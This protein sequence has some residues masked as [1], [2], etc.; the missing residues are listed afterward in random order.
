VYRYFIR[1]TKHL[2]RDYGGT[3]AI[4]TGSSSG[5]GFEIAKQLASEGVNCVLVGRD[6]S[7]LT[8]AAATLTDLYKVETRVVSIDASSPEPDF[9]GLIDLCRSLPCVSILVNNVGVHNE[10]P[11]NV[12]DMLQGDSKRII[13]VNC[14]F[15]TEIIR[16]MV[17]YLKPKPGREK[18]KSIIV[19]VGSLTSQMH[20]PMLSVYAGT[21]A[22]LEHFSAC[23]AAELEPV[24]IEVV[25]L[26]PGIT[27][28]SM[29]GISTPSLFCPTPAVMADA[30]VRVVGRG[31]LTCVPYWPHAIL[32]AVN[33]WVP[34]S[35]AWSA[36][37]QMHSVKRTEMLFLGQHNKVE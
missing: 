36:V 7:R 6:M 24:G 29:S 37:R 14:L 15:Q 17:P 4:I 28:G 10:V 5:I 27:T 25:C 13:T 16:C 18:I 33:Q 31:M 12:S 20:M 11:A 35:V 19:N 32:D 34:H 9:T 23:L 26:R 3:F 30:C 1:R 8:S 2:R 21:K 22:F